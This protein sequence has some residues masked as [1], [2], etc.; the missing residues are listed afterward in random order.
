MKAVEAC[1]IS[2]T[3]RRT[4]ASYVILYR[5]CV[6]M[7][8]IA[9]IVLTLPACLCHADDKKHILTPSGG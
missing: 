4:E 5:Q 2:E 9:P 7:V 3:L 8:T 6:V 1:Y